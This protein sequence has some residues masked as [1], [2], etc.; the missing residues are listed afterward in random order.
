MFDDFT[1][2]CEML[3]LRTRIVNPSTHG[4]RLEGIAAWGVK[5]IVTSSLRAL[6]SCPSRLF[7]Q[8]PQLITIDKP[9][10]GADREQAQRDRIKLPILGMGH[11][12]CLV[13]KS[14]ADAG[15]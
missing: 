8:S 10:Q 12:S 2:T 14:K 5:I 11:A 13:L 9:R 4:K 6:S 15:D 7:Q 3:S 1:A